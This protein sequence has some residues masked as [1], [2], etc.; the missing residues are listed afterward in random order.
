MQRDPLS[1]CWAEQQATAVSQATTRETSDT[2][3][4]AVLLRYDV[5]Q[6]GCVKCIF[7]LHY[8][9]LIKGYWNVPHHKSRDICLNKLPLRRTP[10]HR[11]DT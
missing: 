2:L 9:H 8:F 11:S 4:C 5:W 1:Q 7:Y 10:G 3:Q 6:N